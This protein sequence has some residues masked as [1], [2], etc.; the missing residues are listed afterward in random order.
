MLEAEANRGDSAD[1]AANQLRRKKTHGVAAELEESDE[2]SGV[3]LVGK[4]I[5]DLEKHGLEIEFAFEE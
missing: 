5:E 2:E 4:L 1:S 3:G